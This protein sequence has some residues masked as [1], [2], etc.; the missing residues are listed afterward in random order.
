M[1]SIFKNLMN[2]VMC[3][4]DLL[5]EM[6]VR[7]ISLDRKIEFLKTYF[8]EDSSVLA[9]RRSKIKENRFYIP[10]HGKFYLSLSD[11]EISYIQSLKISIFAEIKK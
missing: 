6:E 8:F 7:V 3:N 10:D 9:P 2:T 5:N 11:L 4:D 1:T